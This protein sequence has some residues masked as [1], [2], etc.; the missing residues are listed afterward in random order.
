MGGRGS[1]S[2][3]FKN[4]PVSPKAEKKVFLSIKSGLESGKTV[5]FKGTNGSI[6][7]YKKTKNGI[8]VTTQSGRKVTFK[9][10]AEAA[11]SYQ[12]Y[13]PRVKRGAQYAIR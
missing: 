4:V 10:I 3:S 11:G 1:F 5:A 7:I 8:E 12:S 6:E 2:F 13:S 9:N